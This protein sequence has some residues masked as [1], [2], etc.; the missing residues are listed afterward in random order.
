MNRRGIWIACAAFVLGA[1]VFGLSQAL[2]QREF[3]TSPRFAA[4]GAPVVRYQVVTVNESEVIIMDMTTG[5]L[6][7]ARPRDVKPYEARPRPAG[8]NGFGG[9][10]EKGKDADKDGFKDAD[11]GKD[12]KFDFKD[13]KEK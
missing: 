7:S 2:A 12:T 3:R 5:D 11:K 13:K 10:K 9:D 6:Y 4:L 1:V 8:A